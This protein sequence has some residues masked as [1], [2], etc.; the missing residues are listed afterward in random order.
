MPTRHPRH[1]PRLLALLALACLC[2]LAGDALA[3]KKKKDTGP[4]KPNRIEF[5][6]LPAI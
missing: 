5:G 6:A 2:L 3:K 4:P 1:T